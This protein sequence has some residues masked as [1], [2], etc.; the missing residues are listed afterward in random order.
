MT[1]I[2]WDTETYLFQPGLVAPR[3]VCGSWSNGVSHSITDRDD[4]LDKFKAVLEL[5]NH[6]VGVNITGFD[7]P[8]MAVADPSLL[9]L[10][11]Q[12]GDAG[13]FHDVMIRE[14][15]HDIAIDKLFTD[16]ETGKSFAKRNENGEMSGR[17]SLEILYKRH[18]KVDISEE[19]QGDV[20]RYK[21]ASLDGISLSQW[22]QE[23]LDYPKRDARRALEVFN[24]QK[25]HRNLCDEQD[26][27]RKA[28][29]LGFIRAWGFRTDGAYIA[30]LEQEVDALWDETRKRFTAQKIY[31]EDGTKDFGELR[32]RVHAAYGGNPPK[33]EGGA[34]QTD[35]DTLL[36]SGD[37]LLEDLG[38]AGKNDKRKTTYLPF[39][40]QGI[41]APINP[42][43]NF[44]VNTGRISSDAQQWPQKG[45]I[46]E[47][48]VARPGY[49]LCSCDWA[50]VE[51]RTMSERCIQ[52]SD[53][54]FSLMA[55]FIN[56]GKDVHSYVAGSFLNLS[57]EEFEIRKSELSSYRAVAKIFN[58]GKGGGAGAFAIA[59]GAKVKDNIRFCLSLKRAEKCGT[60]LVKGF[61]N[62]KEVRCCALCVNI[63][64]E[65]G[66]KWLRAWPEQQKLAQK[67]GRLT[68]GN[69]KVEC[70]VY[71]SGRVRGNCGYTQ[72]L[73]SSFQGAAGDGMGRAMW[74]IERECLTDRKSA[75]WGARPFLN[76]HDELLAELPESRAHDAAFRM[77][78]IMVHTMNEITPHVKNE[79]KPAI[80]R[81]LFKSATEVY[82]RNGRLKPW[83]PI[84]WTWRP[85]ADTMQRD[86]DA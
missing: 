73:N 80:M 18:F 62:G 24:A 4:T 65:L 83:W 27:T 39:M 35:R 56:S 38:K 37:P 63:A 81:R 53:I 1:M 17:Y 16:Y 9:P 31:R 29:A 70:T 36:E 5:G 41:N 30:H 6:L 57:L 20:W 78:E 86:N 19:K 85:D 3:L 7:L 67:A 10:I 51:L 79:V 72:W 34:I 71:S 74:R 60:S 33:T 54:G 26:Q 75:L 47:C 2:G 21:Y 64:K 68:Q 52:D 15:L 77:A 50:G 22:P 40:K 82:D 84:G 58:F 25:N 42:E 12:A 32:T 45:G 11:F 8:V 23:A 61:V 76:I 55:D 59:Y 14:A 43:F 69:R 13:Q 66:A 28:L 44:L 48:I 49:V 46:R